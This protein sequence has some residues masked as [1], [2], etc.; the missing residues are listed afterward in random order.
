[1]VENKV[2]KLCCNGDR[3]GHKTLYESTIKYVHS[4]VRRY[5]H[6]EE[7]RKDVVQESYAKIFTNIKKYD[8]K[9]GTINTWI[10]KVTINEC[11]MH[12]RKFKKMSI[13][14]NV[15]VIDDITSATE[16]ELE[17]ITRADIERLLKSMPDGYKII[18]LLSVIDG[19]NHS[20]IAEQLGIEKQTSRSQLSRAKMWVRKN[21]VNQ[22]NSNAYGL[23]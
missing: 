6:E 12:L 2:I 20:E 16:V 10:R 22:K 5:V 17:G 14:T 9:K 8:A 19:Y 3:R 11:L 4:T 15:E 13:L 18:F 23:F 7:D 1:M 21:I